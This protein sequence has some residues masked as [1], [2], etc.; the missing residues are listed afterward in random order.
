MGKFLVL[1][2]I[3]LALYSICPQSMDRGY[4]LIAFIIAALSIIL[5][6]RERDYASIKK[7]YLR[8]STLF[9]FIL[10]VVFYQRDI[11]YLIGLLDGTESKIWISSTIV[12]RSLIISNI[13]INCFFVGY[14]YE[15]KNIKQVAVINNHRIYPKKQYL[16]IFAYALFGLFLFLVDKSFLIGGYQ[17]GQLDKAYQIIVIMQ[18]IILATVV[19]YCIEYKEC[20]SK[21]KISYFFRYPFF[22]IIV[23]S[24]IVV[25]SGRRTEAL[26]VLCILIICLIYLKGVK[27]NF[28]KLG[29]AGLLFVFVFA[30]VGVLRGDS[31]N[32]LSA[33]MSA[34][35]EKTSISPVTAELAGSVNTLHIA[36]YS[37]PD[38]MPYNMGLSFVPSFA[39]LV[40]GLDRLIS[41]YIPSS[42]MIS[43]PEII[44]YL[45]WG[46]DDRPYGLGS[47]I[48]ADVYIS[49]G[50]MGVMAVFSLLGILFRYLE[51]NTFL[52]SSSPYILALSFCVFSQIIYAS[53][54]GVSVLF[55][56]WTYACLMIYLITRKNGKIVKQ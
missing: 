9:V 41:F 52:R 22:L 34:L 24:G 21:Q 14:I 1:L 18:S 12:A 4:M 30:L 36:V 46:S 27:M 16:C 28:K 44:T 29:L 55:L 43:S 7:I 10:F 47:S 13:A 5:F 11:D 48:I 31:N 49:F 51:I 35:S 39:L 6:L 25:L 23:Y 33:G 50:L 26:R 19:L 56:S 20:N 45:Y 38:E 8:H 3:N 17:G 53:R 40:P 32:G 54:T 37:V 42:L 2:I 15:K